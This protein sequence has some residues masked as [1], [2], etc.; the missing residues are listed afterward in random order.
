MSEE[1]ME[2]VVENK[3]ILVSLKA[4]KKIRLVY[5]QI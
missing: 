4:G 1:K 3:P 5:L 2:Y